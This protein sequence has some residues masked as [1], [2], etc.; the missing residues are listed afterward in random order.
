[1][2]EGFQ[3]ATGLCKARTLTCSSGSCILS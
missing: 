1:M 2:P 3:S